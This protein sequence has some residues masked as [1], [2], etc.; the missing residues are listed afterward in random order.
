MVSTQILAAAIFPNVMDSV[1][2]SSP[3]SYV[4][5]LSVKVFGDDGLWET[6]GARWSHE[7]GTLMV[8]LVAS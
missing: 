3:N 8:G 6:A 5:T 2:L 1:F 7:A 4:L